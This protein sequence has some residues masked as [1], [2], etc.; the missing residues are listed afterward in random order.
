MRKRGKKIL[1]NYKDTWDMSDT[2]SPIIAN[3]LIKFKEVVLD[4]N[5]GEGH[6]L[7]GIPSSV[8]SEGSSS[9]IKALI[10][11][12]EKL[13]IYWEEWKR[14][15]DCMIY[16][17]SQDEP[18]IPDLFE[19]TREEAEEGDNTSS[20]RFSIKIKDQEAYDRYKEEER[21]HSEKVQ[22]GLDYFAKHFQDLWW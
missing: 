4:V 9:D 18:E 11:E 16:A 3:G 19:Y 7:A 8:R 12:D 6:T 22:E 13:N 20:R 17:F 1:F 15:V 2:L 14:R 21:L 5:N 10:T